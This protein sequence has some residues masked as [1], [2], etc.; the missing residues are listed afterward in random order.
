MACM[1][2]LEE[3]LDDWLADQLQVLPQRQMSIL[4]VGD[5]LHAFTPRARILDRR[6]SFWG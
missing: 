4:S 5:E 6:H 3:E 1:E 2:Y